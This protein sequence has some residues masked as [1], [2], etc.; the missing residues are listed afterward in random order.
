MQVDGEAKSVG[1]SG[2]LS[3]RD[4]QNIGWLQYGN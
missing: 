2:A 3:N 1:V 4:V